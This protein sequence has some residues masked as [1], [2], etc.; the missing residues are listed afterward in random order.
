VIILLPRIF[1]VGIFSADIFGRNI[2]VGNTLGRNNIDGNI[3]VR[4]IFGKSK[5]NTN[6]NRIIKTHLPLSLLPPALFEKSCKV[7]YVCRN[8]KDCFVSFYHFNA[9]F[10]NEHMEGFDHLKDMFLAGNLV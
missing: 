6:F 1:F 10:E 8:P 7:L 3:F 5:F 9:V 4:N 2:L